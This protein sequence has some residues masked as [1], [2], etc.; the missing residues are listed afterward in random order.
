M[1][2]GFLSNSGCVTAVRLKQTYAT[3][4]CTYQTSRMHTAKIQGP[5]ILLVFRDRAYG[6]GC[7]SNSCCVIVARF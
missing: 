7:L 5:Q 2:A 3:A 6:T 4:H 1:D